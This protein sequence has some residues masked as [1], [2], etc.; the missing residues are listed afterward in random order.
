[1][2]YNIGINTRSAKG[3]IENI[4]SCFECIS[5]TYKKGEYDISSSQDEIIIQ[6]IV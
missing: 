3:I 5:S 6:G 1:M 2:L 4:S